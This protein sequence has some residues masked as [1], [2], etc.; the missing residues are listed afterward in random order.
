MSSPHLALQVFCPFCLGKKNKMRRM[1]DLKIHARKEHPKEVSKLSSDF[2]VELTGF[3]FATNPKDYSRAVPK[4]DERCQSSVTARVIAM[5]WAK[6]CANPGNHVRDLEA[7]WKSADVLT[8]PSPL[9]SESAFTPDYEDNEEDEGYN[10]SHPQ[11]DEHQLTLHWISISP[12]GVVAEL[13]VEE[14]SLWYVASLNIPATGGERVFSTIQRRIMSL[15]PNPMKE[16]PAG[17]GLL[18]DGT[19]LVWVRRRVADILKVDPTIIVRISSLREE[20]RVPVRS[21]SSTRKVVQR[22]DEGLDVPATKKAP[23][24]SPVQAPKSKEASRTSPVQASKTKEAPHA[25]PARKVKRK[26]VPR[27][28]PVQASRSMEAPQA[29]PARKEKRKEAPQASAA[30]ELT[31]REATQVSPVQE[32]TSKVQ[33]MEESH[34]SPGLSTSVEEALWASPTQRTSTPLEGSDSNRSADDSLHVP[35][36]PPFKRR[37]VIHW[38]PTP[39]KTAPDSL[40][41]Y[42]PTP[43]TQKGDASSI[44]TAVLGPV[45]RTASQRAVEILSSG[46]MPL[47]PPARR[48]SGDVQVTL[49]GTLP[50][51]PKGWRDMRPD[52]KLFA[53]EFAAMTLWRKS[54]ETDQVVEVDRCYLLDIYNVLGLPGT[55]VPPYTKEDVPRKARFYAYETI[56]QIAIGKTVPGQD[57]ILQLYESALGCRLETTDTICKEIRHVNLRL[58]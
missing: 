39:I 51:P 33:S 12:V 55:G 44:L 27:T 48:E 5:A 50:W 30:Q 15:K 56:R 14:T 8:M 29:S 25:S 38:L 28:S 23:R 41:V 21:S 57:H 26:D 6:S 22:T 13:Y 42:R 7:G 9:H 36:S 17:E 52:A 46:C 3:W 58:Q 47:V 16:R 31:S 54:L 45:S 32:L 40:A 2:F 11:M 43:I 34:T 20:V 24:M 35:T 53:W 18:L 10:P 1:V 19:R 4:P 49:N 37:T